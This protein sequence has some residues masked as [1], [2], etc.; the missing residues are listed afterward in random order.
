[1]KPKKVIVAG[2][3][4]IDYLYHTYSENSPR[5][6]DDRV[7]NWQNAM[8]TRSHVLPGGVLLLNDFVRSAIGMETVSYRLTNLK[9][10]PSAKVIQSFARVS[11][12]DKEHPNDEPIRITE[13]LGY[14][15]PV[16]GPEQYVPLNGDASKPDLLIIDDSGN[17]FR[18]REE[19]WGPLLKGIDSNTRI[20]YKMFWPLF[21]GPLYKEVMSNYSSRVVLVIRVDALR[22]EGLNVCKRLSW[23]RS[24]LD[25]INKIHRTGYLRS[26][27][28]CPDIIIRFGHE[29][30]LHYYD[31]IDKGDS[32]NKKADFYYIPNMCEGELVEKTN[33]GMQGVTCPFVANIAKALLEGDRGASESIGVAIS[34]A[35][36]SSCKLVTSGYKKKDQSLIYPISGVLKQDS[37]SKV[38][39]ISLPVSVFEE[40]NADKWSILYEC[41]QMEPDLAV[42]IKYVTEGKSEYLEKFAIQAHHHYL[43]NQKQK[44]DPKPSYHSSMQV[45][46]KL[47]EDKKDSNRGQILDL[48]TKLQQVQC[49]YR[50]IAEGSKKKFEF[51]PGEIELLAEMEHKRWNSEKMAKGWIYGPRN[52]KNKVHDCLVPWRELPEKVKGFDRDAIKAISGILGSGG[53]MRCMAYKCFYEK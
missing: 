27:F 34:K 48:L 42:A 3:I 49:F 28:D 52:D 35:I 50:P 14:T 13:Y 33:G 8:N 1:M 29:G 23:E 46:E 38:R 43:I 10:I 16:T 4:C 17:G 5:E 11:G 41:T 25:F 15:G 51:S 9:N 45:W 2:D 39:K 21:I 53:G 6:N 18:D 47:S 20:I 40:E 24:V 32:P 7:S 26:K 30:A 37:E 44:D 22:E 31:D 36:D 12:F 19:E